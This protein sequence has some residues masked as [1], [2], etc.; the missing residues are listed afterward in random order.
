MAYGDSANWDG[1]CP[2]CARKVVET[3]HDQAE[4]AGSFIAQ[5]IDFFVRLW[6]MMF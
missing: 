3:M 6:H 4:S 5:I 2:A 1:T